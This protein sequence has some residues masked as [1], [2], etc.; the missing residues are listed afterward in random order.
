MDNF[1][2]KLFLL[3]NGYGGH[4]P[5]IGRLSVF[6]SLW[7][8]Y[9]LLVVVVI[10]P[11]IFFFK[12]QHVRQKLHYFHMWLMYVGVG[13]TTLF[14]VS[15]LKVIT[16]IARPYEAIQTIHP[17]LMSGLHNSFPSLHSALAVAIASVSAL[18]FRKLSEVLYVFALLI[19]TSRIFVGAHYPLD[20]VVGAVIGWVIAYLG[21]KFYYKYLE[22]R[23]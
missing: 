10:V 21:K 2:T 22:S 12:E 18:W 13:A 4:V 1:N 16:N 23:Q 9:G 5:L 7:I 6:F 8:S 17:L 3:I 19:M 15:M 20:V 11:L 14:V